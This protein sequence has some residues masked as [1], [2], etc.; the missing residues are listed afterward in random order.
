MIWFCKDQI[1][2]KAFSCITVDQ[3]VIGWVKLANVLGIGLTD[4]QASLS[5]IYLG[6]IYT[7]VITPVLE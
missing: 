2:Y 5:V 3:T 7:S 4:D 1:R 6:Y